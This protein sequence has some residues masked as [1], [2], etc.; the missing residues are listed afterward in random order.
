VEEINGL[1]EAAEIFPGPKLAAFFCFQEDAAVSEAEGKSVLEGG[2]AFIDAE[3]KEAANGD[4]E[5]E[6]EHGKNKEGQ[7]LDLP[8]TKK[9][10]REDGEYVDNDHQGPDLWSGK[11]MSPQA[12]QYFPF[13]ISELNCHPAV[14]LS[15]VKIRKKHARWPPL[16]RAPGKKHRH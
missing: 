13:F 3:G 5:E 7:G 14:D 2:R 11:K 1:L 12:I 6:P 15:R 16:K 4:P 9:Y 10:G 8:E